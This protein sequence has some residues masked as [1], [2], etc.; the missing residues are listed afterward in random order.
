MKVLY[1]TATPFLDIAVEIINI[2]KKDFELHVLIELTPTTAHRVGIE[3]ITFEEGIMR[4]EEILNEETLSYYKS[5]FEGCASINFVVN[6]S[7]SGFSY[8]TFKVFYKTWLFVRKIKTDIIHI[9]SISLRALGLNPIIFPRKKFFYTIHDPVPHSG[10]ANWKVSLPRFLFLFFP[11]PRGYFFYS[12][13]AKKQFM[14]YYKKDTYP[15]YLLKMYPYSIYKKYA[16]ETPSARK[17]ILF[18]GTL[19]FYKGIDVLLKAMPSV[20]RKFP[21]ESLVVAGR[22]NENYNFNEDLPAE[23]KDK[24]ILLD[25]YISNLD[26]V[27][28]LQESKLVICP[29][30]DATQSGVLMTA[31]AINTPVIASNVGAFPEYIDNNETGMLVPASDSS[32]LSKA[33]NFGLEDDLYLTMVYNISKTNTTNLWKNNIEI[34]SNAYSHRP[35]KIN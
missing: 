16:K 33:I 8:S 26:L 15:K 20:F 12:E 31:N 29:Y 10:E 19:S 32:E 18:F 24:I 23:Y 35:K 34:I 21:N 25:H 4:P 9:E 7:D 11:Y 28:L 13:F 5:Y 2:L 14:E 3:K 17:H 1:Y 30:L 6:T 27:I 22:R